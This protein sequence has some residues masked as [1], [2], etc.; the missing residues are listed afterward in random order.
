MKAIVTVV[1]LTLLLTFQTFPQSVSHHLLFDIITPGELMEF[2]RSELAS[3][4]LLKNFESILSKRRSDVKGVFMISSAKQNFKSKLLTG[5][6]RIVTINK[7]TLDNRDLEIE[8]IQQVW[9]GFDWVDSSRSLKTYDEN[10]NIDTILYQ[11][12]NDTN[13]VNT[14]QTLNSYDGSNNLIETLDQMWD[15]L[16][17]VDSSKTSFTY[18]SNNN[19]IE[20][21]NQLWDGSAWVNS[22][23]ISSSYDS[24]NNLVEQLFQFWDGSAWINLIKTSNSYDINNNLAEQLVQFWVVS[25]WVD[26]SRAFNTY[27]GNNNQIEIL[28]QLWADSVWVNSSMTLNSF[29]GNNNLLE[30][31]NQIWEDSSW[32]NSGLTSNSYNGNNNLLETLFQL[33][34]D[35][36]WVN[37]SMTSNTY[38]GNNNLSETVTLL[39]NGTEWSNDRMLTYT[40]DSNNNV[41]EVIIQEG[42]G[43]GWVNNLRFLYAYEKVI[44]VE[45]TSF[46]A[47]VNQ[48]GSVVL[49]WTTATELNS[50]MFKIE[51]R[52]ENGQYATIGFVDGYGTTTEPQEYT[53]VDNTVETGTYFYRLKQIDFGGQFEYSDEIEVEVNGPLTFSLEQNYPNPF[54]PFTIIKYSVPEN[55]FVKLSVYNLTGEEVNVLVNGQVNTGFY[56]I[57]FDATSLPSGIYFYIIQAG[58]FVETKKMVLMK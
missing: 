53:Y 43:L 57:E 49:N 23:K 41:I 8:F 19:Q 44:P 37:S 38:D 18:D 20:I 25:E 55:G 17:W 15:G 56:E 31:L 22:N 10:L 1:T 30:I 51:R 5:E 13:W 3:I 33:W 39:W 34:N 21:L 2:Q 9:D 47:S 42:E 45:L 32:V 36:S 29:N 4:H 46:S 50:Q 16:T 26:F 12:L 35:S 27:D 11:T 28:N 24:N 40:Y 6:I 48:E 7:T 52:S 14:S 54:N 58:S